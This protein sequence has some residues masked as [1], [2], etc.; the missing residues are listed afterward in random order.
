[1]CKD[2][3]YGCGIGDVEF[4]NSTTMALKEIKSN[5]EPF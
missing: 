1:M 2:R 5:R 3:N 4:G